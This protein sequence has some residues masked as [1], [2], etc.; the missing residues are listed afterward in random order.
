MIPSVE[1][2][3]L[4]ALSKRGL[5]QPSIT[6]PGDLWHVVYDRRLHMVMLVLGHKKNGRRRMG[7][8][9]VHL[10]HWGRP[11]LLARPCDLR[12]DDGNAMSAE[13]TLNAYMS[14]SD[15]SVNYLGNVFKMLPFDELTSV[16][17]P[18]VTNEGKS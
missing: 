5:P 16:G 18:A 4:W 3:Q 10:Y 6:R 17:K 1:Y 12:D 15:T 7:H 14:R 2:C 8:T 13:H 11:S 9:Y